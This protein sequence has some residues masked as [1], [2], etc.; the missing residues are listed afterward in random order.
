ML[1]K[2]IIVIWLISF[3]HSFWGC[4]RKNESDHTSLLEKH[5]QQGE[6]N[7]DIREIHLS[8]EILKNLDLEWGKAS[9]YPVYQEINATG[10][11][12]RDTDKMNFIFSQSGGI[13]KKILV[14]VGQDVK[15]GQ[16][17]LKINGHTLRSPTQGTILS[18]NA[19]IDSKVSVMDPLVTVA[20]IDLIRVIFDVYPKDMDKVSIGQKVEVNLIGHGKKI[21]P[22]TI[23]YL[24]PNLDDS[25][26]T[27]KVGA[28]VQ[29]IDH[30]LKFGMFVEGKIFHALKGEKLRVPEEAVVELDG[31]PTVFIPGHKE[32]FF[33]KKT[34]KTGKR[35]QGT[36]EIVEGLKPGDKVVIKGSFTIKSEFLRG[37]MGDDD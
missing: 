15:K 23:Q 31:I 27:L 20:N 11:V 4:S 2:L 19:S 26:Q 8:E 30:H 3:L 21:F 18:I 16:A 14:R 13:I 7:E 25:S 22:G 28:D 17:L 24:S 36:I 37:I 32:G 9:I 34:V 12:I 33:I 5:E 29:N 10:K 6:E 35:A 1:K